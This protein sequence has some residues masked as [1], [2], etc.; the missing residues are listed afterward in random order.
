MVSENGVRRKLLSGKYSNIS[1]EV[2]R[3]EA[4]PHVYLD[5]PL[6]G[7]TPEYSDLSFPQFFAGMTGKILSEID[8]CCVGTPTEN[9]L[10]HLNRIASYAVK[11]S[12]E[13]MLAFNSCVFEAVEQN[14]I[15]WSNWDQ[16]KSLH[17]KHLDSIHLNVASHEQVL[18]VDKADKSKDSTFVP[19][20]YMKSQNICIKFQ[21][22]ICEHESAHVIDSG[23]TILHLCGLCHMAEKKNSPDH[24][25]KTCPIKKK[26]VF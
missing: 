2:R 4:W 26:K 22:N 1:Q 3:Q 24:G 5:N 17:S 7:E 6:T 19:E 16:I 11:G 8:P 12:R 25:F 23:A 15:S 20:S 9:K 13:T 18:N 10:K 21:N 14:Q